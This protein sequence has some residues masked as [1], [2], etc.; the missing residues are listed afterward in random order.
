MGQGFIAGDVFRFNQQEPGFFRV[1]L[2]QIGPGHQPVKQGSPV[3]AHPFDM[4]LEGFFEFLQFTV[5][6]LAGHFHGD[7]HGFH[8]HRAFEQP[9]GSKQPVD[10]F[11]VLELIKKLQAHSGDLPAHQQ[12]PFSERLK[13]FKESERFLNQRFLIALQLA[14]NLFDV[15]AGLT[16]EQLNLPVHLFLPVR[17]HLLKRFLNFG[18]SFPDNPSG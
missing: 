15:P 16:L 17:E 7:R 12:V 5:F 13:A 11:K 1:T 4:P 6:I 3:S 10:R 2:L 9:H 14:L 18:Y 8:H